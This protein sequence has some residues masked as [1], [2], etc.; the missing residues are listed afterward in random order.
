MFKDNHNIQHIYAADLQE[1]PE[2]IKR[3]IDIR[4]A[5]EL[6]ICKVPDTLHIPM[7]TLIKNHERFLSKDEYYYLLCHTGQRSY[8]TTEILQE[9]GY[10][11]INVVGG[12]AQMDKYNVRY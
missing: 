3:I 7:Y 8:L 6:Q 5:F 12:I 9:L 10:N 11:I 1:N 2:E 4:E